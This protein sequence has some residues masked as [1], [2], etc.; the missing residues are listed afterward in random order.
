MFGPR[1]DI[2]MV[3]KNTICFVDDGQQ[4]SYLLDEEASKVFKKPYFANCSLKTGGGKQY[5]HFIEVSSIYLFF[6]N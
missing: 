6:V 4:F 5:Q 1:H 2:V 3:V